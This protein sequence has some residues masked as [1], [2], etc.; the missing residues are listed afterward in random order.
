MSDLC[1]KYTK[2]H[3]VAILREKLSLASQ[4]INEE[5][6]LGSIIVFPPAFSWGGMGR[7]I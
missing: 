1:S 2:M 4:I 7:W 6:V 3:L 5:V